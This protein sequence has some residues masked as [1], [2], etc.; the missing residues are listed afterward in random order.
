MRQPQNVSDLALLDPGLHQR[1]NPSG[2]RAEPFGQVRLRRIAA[3]RLPGVAKIHETGVEPVFADPLP[4][5]LEEPFLKAAGDDPGRAAERVVARS[6]DRVAAA[7]QRYARSMQ[8]V[9]RL[10]FP[11]SN[12]LSGWT[13]RSWLRGQRGS[14]ARWPRS[15]G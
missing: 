8:T 4:Q 11:S 2:K 14:S 6:E 9:S 5:E 10:G 15:D 3:M 1:Q 13:S 12:Q 7:G